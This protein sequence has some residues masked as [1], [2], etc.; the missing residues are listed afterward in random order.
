MITPTT[1][2]AIQPGN[3][4]R[5]RTW[6]PEFVGTVVSIFDTGDL[7]VIWHGHMPNDQIH[8]DEVEKLT[9]EEKAAYIAA[10]PPE[11]RA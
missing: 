5:H 4:V 9:D 10:W 7:S 11:E 3:Y 8:P 6:T 1:D 2:D